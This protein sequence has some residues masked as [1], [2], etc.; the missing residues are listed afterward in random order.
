MPSGIF[1]Q[2]EGLPVAH[3]ALEGAIHVHKHI[4]I[5]IYI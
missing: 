1:A 3:E 4:Y 2:L 5:Y